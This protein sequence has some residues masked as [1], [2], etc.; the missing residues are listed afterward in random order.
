M[1]RR[2]V[3][4]ALPGGT[5]GLRCSLPGIDVM[6]GDSTNQNQFSF[7]SDWTDIAKV[8][9]VGLATIPPNILSGMTIP[10]TDLG[11]RPFVEV[12]RVAGAVVYDDWFV[13]GQAGIGV[14]ISTNSIVAASDLNGRVGTYTL[15]YMIFAVP[16]PTQ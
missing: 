9:Q 6:T 1:T 15:L 13:S 3:L 10:F 2:A 11:Y 12:R 8:Q 16:V 7:N 14:Q 5:F 4:G